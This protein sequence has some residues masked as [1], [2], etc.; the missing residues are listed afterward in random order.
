MS[1]NFINITKTLSEKHEFLQSYMR[2]GASYRPVLTV[3]KEIPFDPELCHDGIKSAVTAIDHESLMQC[4]RIIFRG[5]V[6]KAGDAVILSQGDS[7]ND[8]SFGVIKLVLVDKNE[9]A[10][11]IVQKQISDFL[12]H[13]H[14]FILEAAAYWQCLC[15]TDLIDYHPLHVYSYGNK[16]CVTLKHG[17]MLWD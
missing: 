11:L 14:V 3:K 16:A 15:L 13:L 5:V 12:P 7:L 1:N 17:V 8:L 4:E 6:Y 2:A 9:S 10:W